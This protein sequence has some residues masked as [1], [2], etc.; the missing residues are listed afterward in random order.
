MLTGTIYNPN[1]SM[2]SLTP[3]NINYI[4]SIHNT[5]DNINNI[6]NIHNINKIHSIYNKFILAKSHD[7]PSSQQP[8][9]GSETSQ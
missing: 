5:T 7:T 8:R 3:H 2:K 6:N 4:N 1:D 9:P